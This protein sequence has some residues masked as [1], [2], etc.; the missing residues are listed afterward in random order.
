MR[1]VLGFVFGFVINNFYLQLLLE[2]VLE[3][4]SYI[5]FLLVVLENGSWTQDFK[6]IP[7]HWSRYRFL[8]VVLEH[9]SSTLFVNMVLAHCYCSWQR[10]LKLVFLVR[11]LKRVILN[12]QS[13]MKSSLRF[14]CQRSLPETVFL[15]CCVHL[16]AVVVL[17]SSVAHCWSVL[18]PPWV[19]F[20][21]PQP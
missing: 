3:H 5:L 1:A 17:F 9:C 8:T 19:S 16:G 13:P 6:T 11:F 10:F 2:I 4:G 7:E 20:K 21:D 12:I 15:E 14:C 18:F